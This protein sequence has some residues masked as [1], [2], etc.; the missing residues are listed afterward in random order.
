MAARVARTIRYK[1]SA[2]PVF[3]GRAAEHARVCTSDSAAEVH[4]LC[5]THHQLRE[6]KR[7][8]SEYLDFKT[9]P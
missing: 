9:F 1:E 4:A 6:Y 7:L 8:S 5:V 2:P 3:C